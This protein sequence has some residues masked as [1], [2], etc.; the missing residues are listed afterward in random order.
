[1]NT[2]FRALALIGVGRVIEQAI[3]KHACKEELGVVPSCISCLYF[4]ETNE[5]SYGAEVCILAKQRPPARIIAFG[6]NLYKDK[7]DIPF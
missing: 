7:D 3:S 1:M 2:K 5:N 6:C 4:D